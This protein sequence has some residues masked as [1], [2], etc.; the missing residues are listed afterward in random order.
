MASHWSKRETRKLIS[1]FQ[2]K[3]LGE[4]LSQFVRREEVVSLFNERT[5][6]AINRYAR[7][8]VK[9]GLLAPKSFKR[10]KVSLKTATLDANQPVKVLKVKKVLNDSPKRPHVLLTSF[11]RVK[12]EKVGT[13][14]TFDTDGTMTIS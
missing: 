7:S 11:V 2:T 3:P 1:V 13:V 12:V 4:P 10:T 6:D 8:L 5:P 9:K 14:L